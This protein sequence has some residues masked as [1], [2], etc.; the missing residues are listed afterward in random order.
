MNWKGISSGVFVVGLVILLTTFFPES[1]NSH[2]NDKVKGDTGLMMAA[3][4]GHYEVVKLLIGW[5]Q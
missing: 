3:I 5:G 1:R 2:V 4:K